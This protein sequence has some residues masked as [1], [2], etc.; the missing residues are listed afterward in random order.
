MKN[1]YLVLIQNQSIANQLVQNG[2]TLAYPL[3]DFCV[4]LTNTFLLEEIPTNSYI[5]V[6]RVLD[7]ESLDNLKKVLKNANQKGIIFEDLGVLDAVKSLSL[8]KILFQNHQLTNYESVNEY[9]K[10]V[11]SLLIS[12]DITNEEAK[13][14][15]DKAD[16]KLIIHT[17][18]YVNIMYSRRNLISNYH[19]HYELDNIDRLDLEVEDK[20][21]IAVE[22]QYGTYFYDSLPLYNE[23]DHKNILYKFIN[24]A[25]LSDE[26]VLEFIKNGKI[27]FETNE[28]F[29]NTKTIFK[30]KEEK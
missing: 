19:N 23:L 18:G 28:G 3:K 11:D 27:N 30:I 16:K 6:N 4:G 26:D 13:E 8:E 15:L 29:T 14:I 7:C 10:Y 24:T 21:L 9:L 22:N 25:L 17:L 12:T 1:N 20:K 5:Y 2:A